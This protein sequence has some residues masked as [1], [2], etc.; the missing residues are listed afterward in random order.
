MSEETH[1]RDDTALTSP[2]EGLGLKNK[3]WKDIAVG[4]LIQGQKVVAIPSNKSV[5]EAIMVGFAE[6]WLT[7]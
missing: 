1:V 7:L 6:I 3:T 5:E 2:H 4:S